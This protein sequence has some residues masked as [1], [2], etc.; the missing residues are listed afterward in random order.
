MEEL[1]LLAEEA[2]GHV[3]PQW[4]EAPSASREN[5]IRVSLRRVG[6][7]VRLLLSDRALLLTVVLLF[8]FAAG[9]VAA[10]SA[11]ALIGARLQLL[12][13]HGERGPWQRSAA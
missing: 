5:G 1:P 6:S 8:C 3:Q 12:V 13:L 10:T 7:L 9:F 2:P 4:L 11:I